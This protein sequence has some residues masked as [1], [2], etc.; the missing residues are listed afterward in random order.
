M[1]AGLFSRKSITKT[2]RAKCDQ[3]LLLVIGRM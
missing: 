3:E 2:Y 1:N